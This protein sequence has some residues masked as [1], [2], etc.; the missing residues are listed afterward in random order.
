MSNHTTVSSQW[1]EWIWYEGCIKKFPLCKGCLK[2]K[3]FLLRRQV[4]YDSVCV[5]CDCTWKLLHIYFLIV[6]FPK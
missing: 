3:D 6:H 4:D 2:I 5:L 1:V